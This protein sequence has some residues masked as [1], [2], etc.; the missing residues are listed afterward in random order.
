MVYK[1]FAAT[2]LNNFFYMQSIAQIY[3]VIFT[4]IYEQ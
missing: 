1:L 2:N 3:F 4:E